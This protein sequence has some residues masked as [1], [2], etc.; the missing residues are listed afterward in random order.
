MEQEINSNVH[1]LL[2][3]WKEAIPK[4]NVLCNDYSIYGKIVRLST[5]RVF[6]YLDIGKTIYIECPLNV[7]A[8]KEAITKLSENRDKLL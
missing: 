8:I 3:K 6:N 2:Q 1:I 4:G 7:D 5:T